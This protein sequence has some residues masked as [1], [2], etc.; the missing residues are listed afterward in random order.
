MTDPVYDHVLW[1]LRLHGF[2]TPP[3]A[4]L[5]VKLL[6]DGLEALPAD[7]GRRRLGLCA[8]LVRQALAYNPFDPFLHKLLGQMAAHGRP[9]PRFSA[10]HA[11]VG[12]VLAGAAESSLPEAEGLL[13]E[14]GTDPAA[15][16]GLA[17]PER[18]PLVRFLALTRLWEL[19]EADLLLPA[20]EAFTSA[21]PGALAGSLL[22]FAAQAAD[23][24]DLAARLAERGPEGLF[25]HAYRA[26]LARAAGDRDAARAHL[27]RALAFEPAQPWAA[28]ALAEAGLPAPDPMLVRR[29][30]VEVAFY[31][32]NK[33]D[34]TLDTLESLLASDIGPA[35]VTL[36]NNGST[37]F[38]PEDL[39]AGVER[40][41]Q[42][43]AVR[44][45]Q[46]PSNVGA[47]AARN[48]LRAL[49]EVRGA[50]FLAYL[51]DDVL[52]PRDWLAH[53]LQGLTQDLSA[54]VVGPKGVNPSPP[55]TIQYVWRFFGEVGEQRIRF[56]PNAPVLADFGQ[57]DCRRPC[58]SVMGCCHLF[59][60]RLWE[61][62][63]VPDFDVRF[64]PSQV[65][66]L[67]HDIQ[68]WKAGGHVLYDGRVVVVHRQDAGKAGPLSAAAWGHV[69]GNHMKMEAKFSGKELADLDA[70]SRHADEAHWRMLLAS[71]EDILPP[72]SRELFGPGD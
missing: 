13:Q 16:L 65:D 71:L 10:W 21:G 49:P 54:V 59:N 53:Y 45:V 14:A 60:L 25:T 30:Q 4:L 44:L 47:P 3:F 27:V 5:W 55:R 46:L 9:S 23:R 72:E 34:V 12:K 52:L 39:A 43:R 58:L 11:V 28:Y 62:L 20:A 19:G 61:R 37:A 32:Y 64:T 68:I 8:S 17:G 2:A 69:W 35:G 33:L 48:W 41:A 50:D 57:Y 42:G 66:D 67:E 29:Y 18:P 15:V 63:G 36:L 6:T 56:T 40:A 22:A 26:R 38:S 31:T 7:A 51:D 24:P 70:A 1:R